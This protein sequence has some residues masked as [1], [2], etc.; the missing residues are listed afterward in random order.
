M[1]LNE[2]VTLVSITSRHASSVSRHSAPSWVT[3]ALLTRQCT[4]PSRSFTWVTKRST[5]SWLR[6]SQRAE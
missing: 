2:P 3:P 6:T 5:S 1:Q 4:P